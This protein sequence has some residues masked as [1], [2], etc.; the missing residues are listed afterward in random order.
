M[1]GLLATFLCQI[2]VH[3]QFSMPQI[4]QDG[5][6]VCGVPV[7]QVSS[8]V[9]LYETQQDICDGPFIIFC[10]P[11]CIGD[12]PFENHLEMYQYTD[13]SIRCGKGLI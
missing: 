10:L 13:V 2:L 12:H 4:I 9:I 1:E 6:K 7:N 11:Q 5:A 3:D 8:C